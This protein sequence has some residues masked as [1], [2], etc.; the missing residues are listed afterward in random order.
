MKLLWIVPIAGCL[1]F[2][3]ALMNGFVFPI[4]TPHLLLITGVVTMLVSSIKSD[5][6]LKF[7]KELIEDIESEE[8]EL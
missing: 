2:L 7:L 3:L 6:K 4:W 5:K 1:L 8:K